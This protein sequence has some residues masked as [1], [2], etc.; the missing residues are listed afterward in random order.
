MKDWNGGERLDRGVKY[1][2]GS[3]RLGWGVKDWTGGCKTGLWGERL[4]WG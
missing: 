1:W 4:D 3:E 2:A